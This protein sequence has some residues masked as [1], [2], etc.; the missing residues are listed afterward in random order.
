MHVRAVGMVAL[1]VSLGAAACSATEDTLLEPDA[2]DA[3]ARDVARV[4]TGVRDSGASDV[5]TGQRGRRHRF[6]QHD[7]SG[8][9]AG[10][11]S[12]SS[13]TCKC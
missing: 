11:A 10:A 9:E 3:G 6:I 8:C 2:M 1:V 7:T 12:A 4:D 5:G 13:V